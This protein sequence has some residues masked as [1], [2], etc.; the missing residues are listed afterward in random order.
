[1]IVLSSFNSDYLRNPLQFLVD[2][3]IED[4]KV[5]VNY[6]NI[7]T[8]LLDL[9][10]ERENQIVTVLFRLS[11]LVNVT[12]GTMDLLLLQENL[13]LVIDT[14]D[15]VKNRLGARF[16]VV[17][18]PS[19]EFGLPNLQPLE[20]SFYEA[21]QEKA[22]PL[23]KA[24]DIQS[25]YSL[26]SIENEVGKETHIP[27]T[28]RFYTA[29]S[30]AIARKLH[31]L[32]HRPYKVI[33]MDCDDTLW[34][35]IVGDIGAENVSFMEHHRLL[36]T[37]LIEKNKAGILICLCS[38]N[39]QRNVIDV[40]EK[41]H[42]DMPLM[43]EHVSKF[44]IN[45]QLKSENISQL[46]QELN[47]GLDS[48]IFIDDSSFELEEVKHN[49][50]EVL[51]IQAP[52]NKEEFF[53]LK[54]NWAFD[55]SFTTAEDSNRSKLYKED[56]NRQDYQS[57]FSNYIQFLQ[58]INLSILIDEVKEDQKETIKRIS[59]LSAKTNQFN[60]FPLPKDIAEVK[61]SLKDDKV[62]FNV[63]ASDNF[64]D[65]GLIAVAFCR[66]QDKA[67]L[68]DS[69]FVSCRAFKKGIEYHLIKYI[70][71]YAVDRS[72]DKIDLRF[73]K[74]EKNKVA[75]SF[76]SLLLKS[77]NIPYEYIYQTAL[78]K[79]TSIIFSSAQLAILD[80]NNLLEMQNNTQD[81]EIVPSSAVT[82]H[83]SSDSFNK[84]DYLI[85]L[86][87]LTKSLDFLFDKFFFDEKKLLSLPTI[88]SKIF[89][90]CN[91]LLGDIQDN[92]ALIYLGLDSLKATELSYY[93]FQITG[94]DISITILL[95]RATT[96]Q[97][98]I[99]HIEGQKYADDPGLGT[100]LEDSVEDI[101][102]NMGGLTLDVKHEDDSGK[103]SIESSIDKLDGLRSV[104]K[105]REDIECK[106]DGLVSFKFGQVMNTSFQQKRIWFAENKEI[107]HDNSSS[108][109]MMVACFSVSKLDIP[110]FKQ[111]CEQLIKRHDA[112]GCSFFIRDK[113]LVQTILPVED[114]QLA[115]EVHAVQDELSVEASILEE[116]EKSF[117]MSEAPLIRFS[118]FVSGEGR[119]SYILMRIHHGIFDATSLQNTVSE[120]SVLYQG[121]IANIGLSYPKY[122]YSNFINYQ[123]DFHNIEGYQTMATDHWSKVLS[124]LKLTT[125]F[126]Y[127][128]TSRSLNLASEHPCRRH[129]FS[130]P[131]KDFLR[132]K[133]LAQ[134]TKTTVFNLVSSMF[135]ILV[136]AYSYEDKVGIITATNG[137]SSPAFHKVV[138]FFVNLIV[139][140]FDL[141]KNISFVDYA[142][143]NG[144]IFLDSLAFQDLPFEK[145]Q[146]ITQ[147]Q[148]IANILVNPALIYQSYKPAELVLDGEQAV[149]EI[150]KK[151]ILYDL[152]K[153]CRFGAFSLFLQEESKEING[154]IE[155]SESLYSDSFI[156]R[157]AN[158]FISL[159]HN[160][161]QDPYQKL[162]DISCVSEKEQA[163]LLSFSKGPVQ[164][165]HEDLV[166]IFKQQVFNYPDSIAITHNE[167]ALTYRELDNL[168][169]R[170]ANHL[171]KEGV[172]SG[173]PV[174]LYFEKASLFFIAELALLKLGAVFVPLSKADPEERLNFIVQ[175]AKINHVIFDGNFPI[176]PESQVQLIKISKAA[177][178][179][180]AVQ[181]E[182]RLLGP[183]SLDS[184][185]CILYTSGSTGTPKGVTLKQ[186]G[187]VRVVTSANYIEVNHQDKVAQAANL[188]F[189]AAQLECWLAW[190]NGASLVIVDKDVLLDY[191]LFGEKLLAENV[192]VL[193]LTAALF[194]QYAYTKPTI[195]SHLKY[196]LAGGDAVEKKAMQEV[197][198]CS[199]NNSLNLIIGYG[200]T[201][202]S[203]FATTCNVTADI[204]NDFSSIPI[205]RP[206]N[207][208]E[209]R[210]LNRFKKLAPLGAK[211][212]L[213][214]GGDSLTE[215]YLSNPE[216]Q[217]ERFIVCPELLPST[218]YLSG[219]QV[220][221]SRLDN[222]QLLFCGRMDAE[223]LKRAGVLVSLP[224]IEAA[225]MLHP[226]V[227][228]A[229]LVT[230][231]V[232]HGKKQ[233]IAFYIRN[234]KMP[235][236]NNQIFS[237]YLSSKLPSF[238]F[239][240]FYQELDRF[241][242]TPNG[243]LDK[244]ALLLCKLDFATRSTPV[245]LTDSQRKIANLF[246]DVLSLS[247]ATEYE[248]GL[249]DSFFNWGGTSILA[250]QLIY[251]IEQL[252]GTRLSFN[253]L[254]QNAS[255]RAID[256][257]LNLQM[258]CSNL[259]QDSSLIL[260]QKGEETLA[261]VGFIHPAGGALYC[262]ED[263]MKK[264]ML[265]NAFFGIEDPVLS[266]GIQQN[267]S[268]KEMAKSYLLQIED[269]I[270]QPFI[271]SGY[272][273][274]GMLALE[275]AAQLEERKVN[276]LIGVILLDTWVVSCASEPIKCK[277]KQEVLNYYSHVRDKIGE[278][279][280]DLMDQ[281][282]HRY[283]YLQD[284]GFAF[285][286]KK[287]KN[288]HV[289]LLKATM[290]GSAFEN[291]GVENKNNYLL[292]F[293]DE[294]KFHCAPIQG[295]H[296]SILEEEYVDSTAKVFSA[297][298]MKLQK[299]EFNT[300]NT[301]KKEPL[302]F[303][304]SEK[305]SVDSVSNPP[306]LHAYRL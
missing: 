184:R 111:A 73:K 122:Q 272:S 276:N 85:K 186:K 46:A 213:A 2:Q 253:S 290:L 293:V 83:L 9:K 151:S 75:Q 204:F 178:E 278:T 14:V 84:K 286:P 67:L 88:E 47:L 12:A 261:P 210:L 28:P 179:E 208:T 128:K 62:I 74:T 263:L 120:L 81:R 275:M 161:C 94:I 11:D 71:Q 115:F 257:I 247:S 97:S 222:P 181:E 130:I 123:N 8:S 285:K 142:K 291:M 191:K 33:V 231:E 237:D 143:E 249:D 70:A 17:L 299:N 206:V 79:E 288:T 218:L 68:V 187:I 220:R 86:Q 170:L 244:K 216:L 214:I 254:R 66:V 98:L 5:A 233:L 82:K 114:R 154:L 177:L 198:S 287:L 282:E 259:E 110:R 167:M 87:R 72:L 302:G 239:P 281:L 60:L 147:K 76:A 26:S 189:D 243:K 224:E 124:P 15:T 29:L 192:T 203:I 50:P 54:D 44:K 135:S 125:E 35:G 23:V 6:G 235:I 99:T 166:S 150:P 242:T 134:S 141:E 45:W 229:A 113:G 165:Y 64:G 117:L 236:L 271:L 163:E 21:M 183:A 221:L 226:A 31:N 61:N 255:I 96:V 246:R 131:Q 136:S 157:I 190:A 56:E 232:G 153:T 69:F 57:T 121:E 53:A 168:S 209:I 219:D 146:E 22:I 90:L 211:A 48:F 25:Y 289:V 279:R 119:K 241:P 305:N 1:M 274:G 194:H 227:K 109:Y 13:Q 162:H 268:L 149:L 248:M 27:Y 40:F 139:L 164:H 238:M 217:K 176:K 215:G 105:Q 132:L 127:D 175:H 37:F 51:C 144:Q 223:Q 252:F 32:V 197:F 92:I 303:F 251:E 55:G 118:V 137:R 101:S 201:E 77:F 34:Q 262:Y 195:F 173:E 295:T 256:Q 258:A 104:V 158:N 212:H 152:R 298:V 156:Q 30:C 159:I 225:L 280:K 16:V 304:A 95:D 108:N 277:L 306:I 169:T 273:F 4:E 196:L 10:K 292:D 102:Y 20:Q 205:G 52:Q 260:F 36:Q 145:I 228:Q 230:K 300:V 49:L 38:K 180:M 148:G 172:G 269:K 283:R 193:W 240:D 301:D 24:A 265:N 18:C 106:L 140:P 41:R 103:S 80:V 297:Q 138:G 116:A 160:I 42:S 296:Y 188:A 171:A 107:N 182:A 112:F 245:V 294:K 185:V 207:N 250:V 39:E 65:H 7:I 133:Q 89:T 202:A 284:L 63:R 126:P 174:G 100:D 3:F 91:F 234:E 43:L 78:G 93:L 59:I 200:P 19:L 58:S 264:T 270:K 266:H 267:L 199:N 129:S 155:Y